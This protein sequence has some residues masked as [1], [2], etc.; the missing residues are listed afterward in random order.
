MIN[1][2]LDLIF[3]PLLGWGVAGTALATLLAQVSSAAFTMRALMRETSAY[4]LVLRQVRFHK[5]TLMRMIALGLPTGT[6]S[7]PC[8]PSAT[9][10]SSGASTA[11]GLR[12]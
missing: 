10:S 8:T 4:R 5:P 9:R 3:V 11:W 6:S 2:V 7:R 1:I 12:P